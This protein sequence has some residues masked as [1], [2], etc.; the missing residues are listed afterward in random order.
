[1]AAVKKIKVADKNPT[2]HN[3]WTQSYFFFIIKVLLF[4]PLIIKIPMF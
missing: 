4:A 2:P 3:M 1:M